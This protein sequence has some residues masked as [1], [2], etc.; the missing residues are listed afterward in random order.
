MQHAK[1]L[2]HMDFHRSAYCLDGDGEICSPW[3]VVFYL[4]RRF[5]VLPWTLIDMYIVTWY[6]AKGQ[7]VM[8]TE[9]RIHLYR[10]AWLRSKPTYQVRTSG[11]KENCSPR[12]H[13]D[14][15]LIRGNPYETNSLLV[16]YAVGCQRVYI[17]TW[18]LLQ[19]MDL[20]GLN[21]CGLS[22]QVKS[23][24]W[25][26]QGPLRVCREIT[27]DSKCGATYTVRITHEILL[28]D[29]TVT[30]TCHVESRITHWLASPTI[31][32]RPIPHQHGNPTTWNCSTLTTHT[33]KLQ[34]RPQI[35]SQTIL[36]LARFKSRRASL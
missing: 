14:S 25:P 28:S 3:A 32:P 15:M 27:W 34:I 11:T 35:T 8:S 31:V 16:S 2:F 9:S 4:M 22:W 26:N 12:P 19:G 10:C 33:L 29:F 6:S 7:G 36:I 18:H 17:G 21:L 23:F 5:S 13:R 30:G 20:C 24:K 1:S